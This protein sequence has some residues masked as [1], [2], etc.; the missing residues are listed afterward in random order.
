MLHQTLE[1]YDIRI[2]RDGSWRHEGDLIRRPEL[3]KLF[4]R[5][6]RRD[7]A[8]DYWLITPAER[9]RIAVE[10]APFVAVEMRVEGEGQAQK[11]SFRTNIDEWVTA[12]PDHPITLGTDQAQK[13]PGDASLSNDA[14]AADDATDVPYV[15]LDRGLTAR[16]SR[17]VYYELVKLAAEN[18]GHDEDRES[19]G[20]WSDG[21]FF[22]L[23]R[24]AS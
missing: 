7:E 13:K 18:S 21:A 16:V 9:G 22:P 10:D 8:G 3:V 2:E 4:A 6:L 17:S 15:H 11:I 14:T 12:G 23:V 19:I 1:S 20:V 24:A 5:V